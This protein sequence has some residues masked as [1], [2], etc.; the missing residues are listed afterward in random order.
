MGFSSSKRRLPFNSHLWALILSPLFPL[1]C[2]SP[3]TGTGGP[4][5]LFPPGV[6]IKGNNLIALVKRP[7]QMKTQ[8]RLCF[9]LQ[10]A[11][12]PTK[13]PLFSVLPLSHSSRSYSTLCLT[14]SLPSHGNCTSAAGKVTASLCYALYP[15][16]QT[17]IWN[18]SNEI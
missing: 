12:G 4:W 8:P 18:D 13:S 6:P 3:S 10:T 15:A 14:D 5:L 11:A 7:V 1:F 2:H 16:D 9:R 17:A